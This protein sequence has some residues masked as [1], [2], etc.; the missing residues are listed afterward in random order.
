VT[1]S[2]CTTGGATSTVQPC[3][4]VG[5]TSLSYVAPIYVQHRRADLVPPSVQDTLHPRGCN[6]EN[7][8]MNTK[9]VMNEVQDGRNPYRIIRRLA[10]TY[11]TTNATPDRTREM[12]AS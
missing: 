8:Y 5:A 2:P 1:A 12:E 4:P 9:P 7:P 6:I 10:L 11:R 3:T